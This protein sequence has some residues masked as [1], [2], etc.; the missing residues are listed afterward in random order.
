[1]GGGRLKIFLSYVSGGEDGLIARELTAEL[2]RRG[3]AVWD[4]AT[5]IRVGDSIIDVLGRAIAQADVIVPLVTNNSSHSSWQITE[6]SIAI[7]RRSA[8]QRIIPVVVG[9]E[10]PFP[11]LLAAYQGI[12]IDG[13]R[14]VARVAD[15]ISEISDA[16][17][18]PSEGEGRESAPEE[19]IEWARELIALEGER[20]SASLRERESRVRSVFSVVL[21]LSTLV[22]SAV[23]LAT[24][25]VDWVA[26]VISVGCAALSVVVFVDTRSA[27]R[28]E[29]GERHD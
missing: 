29:R 15:V 13:L 2:D 8:G 12:R 23:T 21:A 20:E 26:P 19:L 10:T 5:E 18:Q 17:D 28:R 1:M 3:H 24:A 11:P 27:S 9:K 7:S 4:A 25:N 6:T 22:I 16:P 14:D